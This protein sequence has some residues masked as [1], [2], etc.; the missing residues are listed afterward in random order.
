MKHQHNTPVAFR[1]PPTNEGLIGKT[2][3]NI[4]RLKSIS[5]NTDP[6]DNLLGQ[7]KVVEADGTVISFG[8]SSSEGVWH[9]A[10]S[11]VGDIA[12][13]R[14]YGAPGYYARSVQFVNSEGQVTA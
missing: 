10:F 1:H 9:P 12:K 8:R 11:T 2:R 5:F 14:R 6:S 13:I 7:F 3:S 4:S